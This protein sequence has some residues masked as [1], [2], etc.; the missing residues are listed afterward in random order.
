MDEAIMDPPGRA[1]YVSGQEA[2][3]LSEPVSKAEVEYRAAMA[4]GNRRDFKE[5]REG[6]D[7]V[8]R[9]QPDHLQA[10]LA[11]GVVLMLLDER[12]AGQARLER[13]AS[14]SGPLATK[15][16]SLLINQASIDGRLDDVVGY[17][18]QA[19]ERFPDRFAI[20]V[21]LGMSLM[22]QDRYEEAVP[23]LEA[24]LLLQP[25]AKVAWTTLGQAFVQL[26]RPEDAEVCFERTIELE[27]RSI[28]AKWYLARLVAERG[29]KDRANALYEEA[30]K[31]AAQSRKKEVVVNI[32]LE[33]NAL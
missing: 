8:L 25:D 6:L 1:A 20:R 4:A 5:A 11:L 30:A 19:I 27:K 2:E 29:E 28:Y 10:D 9:L 32:R 14:L 31:S 15:A 23:V 33:Q 16:R 7:E 24:A 18:T 17:H 21:N 3:E 13:I 12:E 26:G 22:D